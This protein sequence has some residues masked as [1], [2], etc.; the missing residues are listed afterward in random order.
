M[1]RRS[2]RRATKQLF[3]HKSLYEWWMKTLD[4]IDNM[5]P[6]KQWEYVPGIFRKSGD[7]YEVVK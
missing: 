6:P 2:F 5:P 7:G 4:E 3:I 1:Q